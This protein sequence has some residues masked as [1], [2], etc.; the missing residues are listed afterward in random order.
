MATSGVDGRA[1][2]RG[3]LARDAA[4]RLLPPNHG[5]TMTFLVA[6]RPRTRSHRIDGQSSPLSPPPPSPLEGRT[7]HG[8]ISIL[9]ARPQRDVAT[10]HERLG[11]SGCYRTWNA[12]PSASAAARGFR[13]T[14]L[15]DTAISRPS[16]W[17]AA[18]AATIAAESDRPLPRWRVCRSATYRRLTDLRNLRRCG[19]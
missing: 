8:S 9:G 2:E 18:S 17:A 14:S 12:T 13:P 10:N 16:R 1:S 19:T 5:C 11:S 6:L 3:T 7:S 15:C 4:R